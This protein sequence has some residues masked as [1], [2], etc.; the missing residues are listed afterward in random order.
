LAVYLP[1]LGGGYLWDDV[2]YVSDNPTLRS[3]GG[4]AGIWRIP[5]ATRQYYPLTYTSFWVEY[6]L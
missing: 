6:R 1:A 4:L 2:L 3:L 5:P